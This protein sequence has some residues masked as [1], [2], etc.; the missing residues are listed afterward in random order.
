M[1]LIGLLP[2]P[3]EVSLSKINHYLAPIVNELKALWEG[4]MLGTYER[5][6][7]RRIRAALIMV[8]CDIPAAK[9]ICGH[10]SA[11]VSCHQCQKH[12]NYEDHQHN[13]AGMED[14]EDW[15]VEQDST[16]HCQNA[17]AWRHCNSD[18]SRKR[19]VKQTCVRWSELLRLPYFDP[20]RFTIVD[21]MHCLFLGISKWIVKRIWVD[22]GILTSNDLRSIQK[23]INRIQVPADLGRIPGKID[24]GEGVS[25]FTADQ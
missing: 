4:V 3:T 2:G 14:M 13:F 7:G 20:I 9:K 25:N 22:E 21:L 8:A 24:C 1:L 15:F 19:F 10:I 5:Q 11:L 12:A 17:L 18:A 16:D 23:T 6:E